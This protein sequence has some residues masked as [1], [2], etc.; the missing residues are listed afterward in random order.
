MSRNVLSYHYNEVECESDKAAG[1]LF[2][3]YSLSF[4]LVLMEK[5]PYLTFTNLPCSAWP[6]LQWSFDLLAE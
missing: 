6:S 1:K 5:G 4:N 2:I 3:K